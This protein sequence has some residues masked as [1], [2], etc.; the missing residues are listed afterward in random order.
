MSRIL[1]SDDIIY[2]SIYNS[3]VILYCANAVM[4]KYFNMK[5]VWLG[6]LELGRGHA[7][8]LIL[9]IPCHGFYVL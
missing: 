1:A 3:M 8:N 2:A 7:R 5:L 9:A 4:R 6:G